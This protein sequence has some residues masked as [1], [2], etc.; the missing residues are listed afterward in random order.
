MGENKLFKVRRSWLGICGKCVDSSILDE[1]VGLI[2]KISYK[3]EGY[4]TLAELP[5][6]IEDF[7]ANSEIK[8]S[9]NNHIHAIIK[10][11]AFSPTSMDEFT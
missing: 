9:I 11:T 2:K 3:D 4:F 1:G 6:T 10:L 8:S 7:S 5:Y